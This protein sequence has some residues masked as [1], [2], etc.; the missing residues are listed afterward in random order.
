MKCTTAEQVAFILE[1][2]GTG[3]LDLIIQ[4]PAEE[5]TLE[6][7]VSNQSPIQSLLLQDQ[8]TSMIDWERFTGLN[9]RPLFRL[10]MGNL[11][12]ED[13]KQFLDLVLD[14]DPQKLD[15]SYTDYN[16]FS[17]SNLLSHELFGRVETIR[18]QTG[19]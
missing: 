2:A 4:W 9:L 11:K 5:G 19:W 14:S 3:P 17:L 10:G 16:L 15:L 13:L 12:D 18:I 7:I 1:Q 8:T 6:L